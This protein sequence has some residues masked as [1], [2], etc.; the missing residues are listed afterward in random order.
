[1]VQ[2]FNEEEKELETFEPN[3]D[4]SFAT[5]IYVKDE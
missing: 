4:A 3:E 5:N 1:M 2:S